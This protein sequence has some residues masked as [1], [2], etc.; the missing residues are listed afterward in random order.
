MLQPNENIQDDLDADSKSVRKSIIY[1]GGGLM[2]V[3]LGT[4]AELILA[5]APGKDTSIYNI[6]DRKALGIAGLVTSLGLTAT[7]ALAD[8]LY[9]EQAAQPPQPDNN[10]NA[11][12]VE[13]P[14]YQHL[15]PHS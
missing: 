6:T 14:D 5:P 2:S 11:P 12:D 7:W 8:Y 4:L 3:G 9:P 15:Q 1:L 10:Q 13:A